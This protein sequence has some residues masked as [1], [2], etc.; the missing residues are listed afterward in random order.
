VAT[1]VALWRVDEGRPRRLSSAAL[2]AERDLETFIEQDPDILGERLLLIGRQVRTAHGGVIDL[3]A[4]DA[5]GALHV[6]ELKRDKT[7]REVL[8]QALDYGSWVG[9]LSHTAIL[10][11]HAGYDESTTFEAAFE[12]RFGAP[13]PEELNTAHSLTI[14][15]ARLDDATERILGYLGDFGVPVNAVF[16]TYFEDEDRR[17][18]AREWLRDESAAEP[19]LRGTGATREPWNGTDWYAAFGEDQIRSW[20]NRAILQ[21]MQHT[22]SIRSHRTCRSEG[23]SGYSRVRELRV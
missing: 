22:A 7:A 18:L 20:D 17:Y 9:T 5:E 8:A 16:F 15:A 4:V 23:G 21:S 12:E 3:L 13:P 14:V 6:L 11:I 10:A 2:S 1:E 19:A